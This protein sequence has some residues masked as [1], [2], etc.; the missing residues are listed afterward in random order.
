ML[1]VTH[2][3]QGE[4]G[5]WIIARLEYQSV[6]DTGRTSHK[7]PFVTHGEAAAGQVA[8]SPSRLC[9]TTRRVFMVPAFITTGKL[10]DSLR[11]KEG[12]YPR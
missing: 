5:A 11:H 4:S 3:V 6:R 12:A 9:L 1:S 7:R 10:C 2:L 8:L